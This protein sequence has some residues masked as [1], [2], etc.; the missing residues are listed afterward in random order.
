MAMTL[1]ASAADKPKTDMKTFIDNLMA[2]MTLREKIGQLNLPVTGDIVTG[3]A[4]SSNVAEQIRQGQVGGLFNLKGAER[5]REVQKVAVEQS[6][7]GIPLIFGMDVIH[8]YETVFPIPFT[9]SW[10][11]DMD[12]IR[13]SA[14]IA[15]VEASAD[16]ICWTFSPMLDIA[17]DPRWGRMAEGGG[18]DPYLGSA[19]ARAMV[20]GYQGTD[21]KANNTVMACVK[22][23]ALYGAPDAGRDYNTVDMSHWR[24]FNAYMPPYKAAIDAGAGS[25]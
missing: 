7:L 3:Q 22:H 13:N 18:E 2:K 23:F 12:A 14:R 25:V 5:I 20:E 11:W 19:I 9:L 16:G 4:K 1:V 8:G 24:M 17:R 21:L 10:S 6:R 15:A